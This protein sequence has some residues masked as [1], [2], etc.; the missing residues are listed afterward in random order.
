[1]G[2]IVCISWVIIIAERDKALFL[3]KSSEKQMPRQDYMCNRFIGRN[4][5]KEKVK[6]ARKSGW[7]S[8]L[9]AGL[10]STKASKWKEGIP[11]KIWPGQKGA[12]EPKLLVGRLS[13]LKG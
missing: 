7:F 4:A 8:D 5:L 13:P 6:E 9:D 11:I 3:S 12:L 10:T 1:M 2:T